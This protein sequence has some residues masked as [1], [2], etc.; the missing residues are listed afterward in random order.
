MIKNYVELKK[1]VGMEGGASALE[2]IYEIEKRESK[3]LYT[4]GTKE[5]V[6]NRLVQWYNDKDMKHD[7]R[8]QRASFVL[9]QEL[10]KKLKKVM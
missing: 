1:K 10:K 5:A 2:R 7:V 8:Y 9:M 3:G 6:Q 4:L